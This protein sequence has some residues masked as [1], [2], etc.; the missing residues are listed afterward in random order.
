MEVD[1]NTN[2]NQINLNHLNLKNKSVVDCDCP[3]LDEKRQI[4][5]VQEY[6][7]RLYEVRE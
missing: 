3:K 1:V 5:A 7:Y 6:L 4:R 2:L